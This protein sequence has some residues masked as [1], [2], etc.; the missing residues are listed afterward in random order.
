MQHHSASE[1]HQVASSTLT[2]LSE[3]CSRTGMLERKQLALVFA[4]TPQ[5]ALPSR[6]RICQSL[7]KPSISNVSAVANVSLKPHPL[8]LRSL[9]EYLSS[10]CGVLVSTISILP[11]WQLLASLVPP[12]PHSSILPPPPM[13][14]WAL[15]SL[16]AESPESR[17]A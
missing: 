7:F 3:I 9:R 15:S 13:P 8:L 1:Y 5:L 10:S 6:F 17:Q 2:T 12:A 11:P 4:I 16:S 14:A